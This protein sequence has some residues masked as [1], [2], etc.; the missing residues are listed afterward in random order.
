MI[1]LYSG[2]IDDHYTHTFPDLYFCHRPMV[3]GKGNK[4]NAR[5]TYKMEV[6]IYSSSVQSI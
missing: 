1:Q 2:G 6:M 4:C 3:A 5:K